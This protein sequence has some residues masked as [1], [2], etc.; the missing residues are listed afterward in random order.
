M[1]A[2][3]P[4]PLPRMDHLRLT[5]AFSGSCAL[6]SY[7]PRE[8]VSRPTP[9]DPA[10]VKGRRENDATLPVSLKQPQ[11][12]AASFSAWAQSPPLASGAVSSRKCA[13]SG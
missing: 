6:G 13:R 12:D 5:S 7:P 2:L 9:I 4:L 8:T 11:R 1:P 10:R 3:E